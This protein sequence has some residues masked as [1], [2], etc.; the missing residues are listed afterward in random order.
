MFEIELFNESGEQLIAKEFAWATLP[1]L[2]QKITLKQQG[3]FE[4]I[5]SEFLVDE[6]L[7][8]SPK[9]KIIVR[10]LKPPSTANT[11]WLNNL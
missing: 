1:V 4:V 8:N 5:G 10:P 2:G 9:H 6:E 7:P 11:G 3:E